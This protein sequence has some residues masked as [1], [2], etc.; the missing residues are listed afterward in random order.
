[1]TDFK[2]SPT[3]LPAYEKNEDP[4][5]YAKSLYNAGFEDLH[6]DY[7]DGK[8]APVPACG[9]ADT[10]KL[11]TALP[12]VNFFIHIMSNTPEA[13]A[14]EF[15]EAVRHGNGEYQIVFQIE[16]ATKPLEVLGKYAHGIA[17]DLPTPIE[18]IDPAVFKASEYVLIMLIKAGA[19]FQPQSVEGIKK[20]VWLKKH[21][22]HIKIAV[23]GGINDQNYKAVADAGGEIL[24]LGGFAY[25][26]IKEGR[27]KQFWDSLHLH[28]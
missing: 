10:K 5:G 25:K 13:D 7:I 21:Y 26:L 3:V 1:M 11:V 28:K 14:K 27:I 23:D 4:I 16:P 19:S 20:I 15:A 12:H 24:G 8:F 18:A 17:V 9:A 22:P 6:I 2:F